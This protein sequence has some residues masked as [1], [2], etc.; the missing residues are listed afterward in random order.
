MSHRR[1][2][3]A[4]VF[5]IFGVLY[6]VGLIVAWSSS[7]A[8][9]TD[10]FTTDPFLAGLGTV[11]GGVASIVLLPH[12][13]S[14]LF[15]SVLA[16]AGFFSRNDGLLLAA[17]ILLSVALAMF[18][19]SSVFLLPVVILGFFGYANQRRLNTSPTPTP[20]TTT[21]TTPDP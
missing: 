21:P 12:F 10:L 4:L 18:F 7:Q 20:A 15:G 17:A 9:I 13:I 6:S 8:A 19:L 16:V 2:K 14:S 1:S 11:A 3:I 5:A